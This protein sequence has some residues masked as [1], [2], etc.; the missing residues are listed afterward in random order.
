MT[1]EYIRIS[2]PKFKQILINSWDLLSNEQR[3][4]LSALGIYPGYERNL[5]VTH[6]DRENRQ[7]W[8]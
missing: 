1:E 8:L 2:V 4:Q 6:E 7:K 5:S 3:S